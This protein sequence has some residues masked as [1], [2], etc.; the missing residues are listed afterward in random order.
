[1]LSLGVWWRWTLGIV[2]RDHSKRLCGG[3]GGRLYVGAGI[4]R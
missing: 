4:K 2:M 3:G 1:M